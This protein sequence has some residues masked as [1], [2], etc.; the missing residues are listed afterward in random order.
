M[1]HPSDAASP[2]FPINNPGFIYDAAKTISLGRV[3]NSRT[4]RFADLQLRCRSALR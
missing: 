3:N 1:R 4:Q 2:L